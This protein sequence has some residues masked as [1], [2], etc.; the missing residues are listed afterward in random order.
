MK[1]MR[2][3]IV[4]TLTAA[5][6]LF[7]GL[8]PLIAREDIPAAKYKAA[9][10]PPDLFNDAS[11]VVRHEHFML[12][13]SSI[14]E[15]VLTVR[16]IITILNAKGRDFGEIALSY[17][18]LRTIEELDGTLYDSNGEEIRTLNEEDED[19]YSTTSGL[20][21]D[22]RMRTASLYHNSYPYTVDFE[23]EVKYNG[24]INWPTWY[25]EAEKASVEFS[26]FSVDLPEG[27]NLRHW[28]N[29]PCSPFVKTARGR[30]TYEWNIASL[31][32]FEREPMGPS[33][34]DQYKSLRIAPGEF[35]IEGHKGDLSSW[36]SFG[37]WFYGLYKKRDTLPEK[38]RQE[39]LELTEN[40]SVR[41]EKIRRVYEHLQAKT[42][43]V[44]VQLG[45]GGWQPF[46]ASYVFERGY[47]DCKALTNYMAS[48]LK[49][50]G[51]ETYPAL[52]YASSIPTYVPTEFS[53]NVF[54]HVILFAPSSSDTLW[55]E[56]T[57]QTIPF[58]HISKNNENRLALVVFP[59]GGSLV[60]TPVS[61][62]S[63]NCQIRNAT[64]ILEANGNGVAEVH[65]R[66]TGN[67]QD[68]VRH[69][70]ADASSLDRENWLKEMIE[71]PSYT[72]LST[73]YSGFTS[74][75]ES[76]EIAF[77]I[78]LPRYASMGGNRLLFSPNLME[79]RTYVPR[80][81][82]VRKYPIVLSYAYRDIDTI[83]YQLPKG[84]SIE[85]MPKPVKIQAAFGSY[86]ANF[87][88]PEIG[89]L[90]YTRL[91]EFSTPVIPAEMYEDYRSFLLSVVQADKSLAS[92]KKE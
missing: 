64:V 19:D 63:E 21:D 72:L 9:T 84:Y 80:K 25:P 28:E 78:Q 62:A 45:I 2:H 90:R 50:I 3:A 24:Y 36:E 15:A 74:K 38:A 58:G 56:C 13:V 86:S 8:Q 73:D 66:Y 71:V 75:K 34:V 77:A 82:E 40:V 68:F 4:K 83:T 67:Q 42:R 37:K 29:F 76:V 22:S 92:L 7:I 46:E 51:I 17:D 20:Y 47:G 33:N 1:E 30:T 52:I 57:S 32:P 5:L 87:S 49:V 91:L 14:N 41:R 35:E 88:N 89:S 39:V 54:N 61:N 26:A 43:Y 16:R 65:A 11:A 60:Q 85:A 69:G 44:S 55:L 10:I 81:L 23:Y 79:K 27:M 53:C 70:L 31:A 48:M 18:R 12:R 6:V 59:E